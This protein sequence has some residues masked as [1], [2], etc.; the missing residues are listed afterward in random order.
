MRLLGIKQYGN[1]RKHY[2]PKRIIFPKNKGRKKTLE[3]TGADSIWGDAS[4]YY[5]DMYYLSDKSSDVKFED[6]TK[7]KH[8]I[9][10]FLDRKQR[11]EEN[12]NEQILKEESEI[13]SEFR[14][15]IK[16][17]EEVHNKEEQIHDDH[18]RMDIDEFHHEEHANF[19]A[20]MI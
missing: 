16:E 17:P 4:N 15:E 19:E 6:I 20:G 1:R 3:D 11:I 5:K 18:E 13:V 9:K 14:E 2:N 10:R 8:D 7:C 12:N